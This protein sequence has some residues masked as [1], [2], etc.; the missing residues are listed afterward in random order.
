MAVTVTKPKTRRRGTGTVSAPTVHSSIDAF[1]N[2]PKIKDNANT[3][4]AYTGVLDRAAEAIGPDRALAD[5]V[6]TEVGDALTELW[7]KAKPTTWNRNRAAVG[8]W[9]TWCATK[10]N[11]TAPALPAA[12]ERQRE[13]EDTTKAVSRSRIDR[14]CRRRD[15]PLREKTLWRML[16]GY[17][18]DTAERGRQ[19]R[20]LGEAGSVPRQHR[21]STA[22]AKTVDQ[23]I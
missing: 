16:Y 23:E 19:R 5:V 1:L 13:P 22:G 9:L 14:L 2:S 6:D 21:W 10:Q 11:W 3:L 15:V 8:S 4:R 17:E 12:V 20:D 7:G 18:R